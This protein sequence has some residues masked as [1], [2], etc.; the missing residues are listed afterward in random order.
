MYCFTAMKVTHFLNLSDLVH[1]FIFEKLYYWQISTV[2]LFI[3][4]DCM[5]PT[6]EVID[7]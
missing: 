3:A 1:V 4:S 7:V 5:W 6:S 2:I